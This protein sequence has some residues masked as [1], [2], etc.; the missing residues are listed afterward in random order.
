MNKQH[1]VIAVPGYV[2]I[3]VVS[4]LPAFHVYPAEKMLV[5]AKRR[6]PTILV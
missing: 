4:A 5:F 2:G 3:E 6:T 1:F